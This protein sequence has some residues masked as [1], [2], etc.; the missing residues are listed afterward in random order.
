MDQS[1]GQRYMICIYRHLCRSRLITKHELDTLYKD[2]VY[3]LVTLKLFDD[4]REQI[5]RMISLKIQVYVGSTR[6]YRWSYS[7]SFFFNA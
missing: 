5:V 3:R 7:Y 1:N 4:I 2:F 6:F